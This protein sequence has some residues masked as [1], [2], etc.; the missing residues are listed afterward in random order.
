[1]DTSINFYEL[2]TQ[3]EDIGFNEP[4]IVDQLREAMFT[5]Y[6]YA[7]LY[8]DRDDT[9]FQINLEKD[10]TGAFSFDTY[11]AVL[12]SGHQLRDQVFSP[13]VPVNE[14]ILL[15]QGRLQKPDVTADIAGSSM[16]RQETRVSLGLS[17]N[18]TQR[19]VDIATNIHLDIPLKQINNP[20]E[21]NKMSYAYQYL[22]HNFKIP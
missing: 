14:A 8:S 3:L 7:S 18:P 19:E 15:L 10:Y 1:M 16:N 11:D 2:K 13:N 9:R 12:T 22:A 17:P 5:E 4:A 6:N 20:D 21:L